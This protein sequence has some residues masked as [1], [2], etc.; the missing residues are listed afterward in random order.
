MSKGHKAKVHQSSELG[1]LDRRFYAGRVI[2]W[3][4]FQGFFVGGNRTTIWHLIFQYKNN[5]F[6]SLD[7]LRAYMSSYFTY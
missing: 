7:L 3:V 6:I 1:L 5:L 2:I 4:N